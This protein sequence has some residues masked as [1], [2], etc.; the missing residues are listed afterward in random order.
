VAEARAST[1][2]RVATDP[3][4]WVV[5]KYPAAWPVVTRK[6]TGPY[7]PKYVRHPVGPQDG[8][9]RVRLTVNP[10]VPFA[11]T[12]TVLDE[13]VTVVPNFDDWLVW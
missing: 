12:W 13:H 6:V 1:Q 11:V 10:P 3:S 2:S 5:R 9:G 4:Q 7:G 8:P